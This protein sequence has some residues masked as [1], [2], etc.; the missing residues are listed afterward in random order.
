MIE[1]TKSEHDLYIVGIQVEIKPLS[2]ATVRVKA[3]NFAHA[4]IS[5]P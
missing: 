2:C 3:R 5:L 1:L 4:V